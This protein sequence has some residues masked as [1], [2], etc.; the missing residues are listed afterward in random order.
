MSVNPS[1]DSIPETI[2]V[3]LES[4]TCATICCVSN[5]V[6]WCFSCFY[7]FDLEHKMLYYKSSGDN[8]H[9]ETI[10]E[11][12][13]VAGTILP[14][15]L[16]KISVQGVQFQGQVLA[17]DDPAAGRATSFY[18]KVHPMALAMPG[19]VWTVQLNYIKMTDSTLGFGKKIIW[20]RVY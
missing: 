8:R 7:A 12:P 13:S 6:P 20:N 2:S 18:H 17:V 16:K 15:K 4:Q 1:A 3:F 14:D 19:Q 9:S 10:A 11:N 5:G